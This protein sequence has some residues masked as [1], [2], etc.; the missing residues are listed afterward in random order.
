MRVT[1]SPVTVALLSVAFAVT[2]TVGGTLLALGG[3]LPISPYVTTIAFAIY[4]VCRLIGAVRARR[5]WAYRPAPAAVDPLAA[6][7]G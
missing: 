1:A 6:V 4:L 2:S 5:G 7:T 3:N